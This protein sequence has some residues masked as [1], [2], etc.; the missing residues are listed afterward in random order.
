MRT[1]QKTYKT[2]CNEAR[3]PIKIGDINVDCHFRNGNVRIG[4][5][6]TLTTKDA[7]VQKA[8]ESSPM[9]GVTIIL[10]KSVEYFEEEVKAAMEL[11]D[12]TD[13]A[14]LRNLLV[15]KFHIDRKSISAPN[16]LKAKVKELGLEL[17]NM[18][19]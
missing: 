18:T 4:Q 11:E 1:Y 6:A 7:V 2:N 12:V 14:S 5:W 19:W 10:D 13:L 3:I 9:Y 16:S 8:I 17:P 15:E